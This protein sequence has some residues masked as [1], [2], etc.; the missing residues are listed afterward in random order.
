MGS[1]IWFRWLGVAGIE[2]STN[3]RVLVIDPF[4]SRFPTR[5][6]WFG[7][8]QPDRELIAEKVQRC[9]FVLVT[10]THWDHFMDV[11][12]VVQ[13]TGAVTFGS[14]NSCQLLALCGIP[15]EKIHKI[16]VG[17]ELTLVDFRIEVR[18]A[19]HLMIPGFTAGPLSPGLRPP[20]RARDYRMDANFSFLISVSGVRLL[21]DPGVRPEK[22]VAA[23]VLFVLPEMGRAYYQSLLDV[24]QP[25]VVVPY[26]WDDFFR[27]LSQPLRPFWK[28]PR[29]ALAPLE[30]VDLA[31]FRRMIG[32]LAPETRVFEPQIFHKVE[33]G[34]MIHK[35]GD[36]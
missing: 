2:L 6:L 22:A 17:D 36:H 15:P 35:G 29:L 9:D 5:K 31:G 28:L 27:P 11:P 8:V 12:D 23:D 30:R 33:L 18:E 7:Q 26:H 24:V 10:H 1:A 13:T 25:K 20:L 14:S 34:R 3:G 4:F 16:Q 21:T 32:Q 19:Q